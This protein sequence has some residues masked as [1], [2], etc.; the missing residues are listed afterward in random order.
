MP[1]P[2]QICDTE[3][4]SVIQLSIKTPGFGGG[5]SSLGQPALTISNPI[6]SGCIT[7]SARPHAGRSASLTVYGGCGLAPS[8]MSSEI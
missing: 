4:G 1:W 5:V 7:N 8:S 2:R 6:E 3:W